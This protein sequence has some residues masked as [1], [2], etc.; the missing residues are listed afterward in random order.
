[1]LVPTLGGLKAKW[2]ASRSVAVSG[3]DR[4]AVMMTGHKV[5]QR[6]YWTGA[7]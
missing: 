2:P 6:W 4:A 3:K 5:D 1:L 7:V